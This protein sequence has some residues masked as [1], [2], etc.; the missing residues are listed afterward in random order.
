MQSVSLAD[1]VGVA[2]GEKITVSC[3]DARLSG[4]SNLAARAAELFFEA[5]GVRGGADIY[6]EKRIPVAA[7]LAGGSAD[8]AA[9]IV[10]LD[11]LY[12]TGL[13]TEKLC[14]IGLRAGADVPFCITG[15][16]MLVSGIGEA[17][18]PAPKLPDCILV[19]TKKGEKASTG[20]LYAKYDSCGA[21]SRPDNRAM[22][23]ALGARDLK[24]VA[25]GLC[26]VFEELVPQ[27]RELKDKMLECGA[28]GASLSGSG[29][30]V[31]GIFDSLEKAEGC[32]RKIGAPAFVCRPAAAGCAIRF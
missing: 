24:S 30:C 17:L 26:N 12:D 22:L 29:P 4:E 14:E 25:A 27:S 19:I 1:T 2:R 16:T 3:S 13:S 32:A 7:G 8:A 21:K 28:L 10:G 5:A 6:I 9:V 20:S 31:F 23:A 11:K 18:S 15:G